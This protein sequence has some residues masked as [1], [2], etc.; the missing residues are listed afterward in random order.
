MQGA[1]AEYPFGIKGAGRSRV[2][3]LP[4]GVAVP[5]IR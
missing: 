1:S 2:R 3:L 4:S 5:V